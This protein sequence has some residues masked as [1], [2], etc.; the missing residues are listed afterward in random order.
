M[1]EFVVSQFDYCPLIWMFCN[2]AINN[3]INKIQYTSEKLAG[4][5]NRNV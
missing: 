5:C 3:R 4:S 1:K 2:R